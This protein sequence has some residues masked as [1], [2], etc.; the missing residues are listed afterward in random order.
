[1]STV[2]SVNEVNIVNAVSNTEVTFQC[3]AVSAVHNV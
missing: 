3:T 1:M 2:N